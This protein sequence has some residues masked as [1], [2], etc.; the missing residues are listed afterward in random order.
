MKLEEGSKDTAFTEAPEDVE[1]R[2]ET[3][4]TQI[5]AQQGKI[6]ALISDTSIVEDGTTKKLKD[7]YASLKLTVN[8]LNSTVGSHTT[9]I[10]NLQGQITAANSN[11]SSLSGKV[12]LVESKQV[13]FEQ[14]LNGISQKV[15]SS[16]SNIITLKGQMNTANNNITAVTNNLDNL[17]IGGRNLAKKGYIT[18]H[19]T[20][21][22]IDRNKYTWSSNNNSAGLQLNADMFKSN[23]KYVLSFKMRKVSGTINRIGGHN[24]HGYIKVYLDGTYNTNN[25]PGGMLYPQDEEIHEIRV[26]FTATNQS[27]N[28]N[29]YI[30]PN[31]GATTTQYTV[32][33]WDIQVE[34]GDKQTGYSVPI[35]DI[36]SDITT[37]DTKLNT[38]TAEITTTKNKVAELNT[39]LD[40]ITQKV[41]S[42]ETNVTNIN[43]SLNTSK[44]DISSL[45]TDNTT[46]KNNI[47]SLNTQIRN[48]NNKVASIETTVNGISSKVSKVESSVATI[49]GN[50]T[51]LQNRVTSAEQKITAE[52][53]INTVTTSSITSTGKMLYIDPTFKYGLNGVRVYNNSN[54]GVVTI[55]RISKPSDCPTTSTHILEIKTTGTGAN[56]G[57]GGFYFGNQTRANAIF[58]YK[59]TA[60]VPKG[61]PIAFA[62]N[63]LGDGNKQG[64]ITDNKGTGSYKEYVYKV[65]CGTSG[66]F[67][68]TGFFYLNGGTAPITWYLASATVYDLSDVG[69]LTG[70]LSSLFA[71][72]AVLNTVSTITDKNGFTVNNGAIRIRDASGN[73]MLE[74]DTSGNLYLRKL[75]NVGNVAKL[76]A[77]D[78]LSIVGSK[79]AITDSNFNKNAIYTVIGNDNILFK[80]DLLGSP[81]W[82]KI[83]FDAV[84]SNGLV[85]SASENGSIGRVTCES[86]LYAKG[87]INVTRELSVTGTTTLNDRLNTRDIY[88]NGWFR[89][90]GQRGIYFQDFGGG[91]YMTDTTWIRAYNSKSIY[92]PNTVKAGNVSMSNDIVTI[93]NNSNWKALKLFRYNHQAMYGIGA[94]SSSYAFPVIEYWANGATSYTSRFEVKRE[95][96]YA[97]GAGSMKVWT[98]KN[99]HG[100]ISIGGGSAG[101]LKWLRTHSDIQCRNYNDSAYS[102]ICASVFVVNS[103]K[104]VKENIKSLEDNKV[105]DILMNNKI[106]H[107][108]LINERKDIEKLNLEARDRGYVLDDNIVSIDNHI[109]LILDDLTDEALDIL[110]PSRTDGI[111]VYA[112]V[113]LLWQV[114]QY[115]QNEIQRIKKLIV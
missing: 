67:S 34:E 78:G 57:H 76:S 49:N 77:T 105:I 114:C 94:D 4:T 25:Y 6:E 90:Y 18:G 81:K 98:D 51:S 40:G 69:D 84:G 83:Y 41:S 72:G 37:V 42:T 19:G 110:Q 26:E 109:G 55:N 48:T 30:Q 58:I 75:L 80:N 10:T 39:N 97:Y 65:Q 113:S 7:T 2:I 21:P 92:T 14:N 79:I 68:S 95:L 62:T 50:I 96:I 13:T 64:W 17:Q 102:R 36:E 93:E 1:N 46:N 82:A 11:I 56:P 27:G 16:E 35:E 29:V 12:Q 38:V 107:Y 52:A 73:M 74:G 61:L 66:S 33:V 47:S 106:K 99:T 85:L 54:N 103:Q 104:K 111:D 91:W 20:T 43:A 44:N 86:N 112:M 23:R 115:Q 22:I 87:S 89:A 45:K 70:E 31:R 5:T 53:I 24:T 59:F 63:S 60:K 108:N 101:Y 3:N 100:G 71:N 15:A 88:A 9:N 28:R 32:N 8:G